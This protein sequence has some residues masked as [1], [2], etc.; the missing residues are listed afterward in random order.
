M[1]TESEEIKPNLY[2]LTQLMIKE[3]INRTINYRGNYSYE[4]LDPNFC[5]QTYFREYSEDF[6]YL[7]Y[8]CQ[9]S[10]FLL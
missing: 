9:K 8:I 7:P 4:N 6:L 2:Y 5:C 10:N 1:L 3:T